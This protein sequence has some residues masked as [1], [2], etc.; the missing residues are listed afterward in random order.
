MGYDAR[1]GQV[2]KAYDVATDAVGK[3]SQILPLEARTYLRGVLPSFK[4]EVLGSK[5]YLL[6]KNHPL[7]ENILEE[8]K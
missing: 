1:Q 6:R 7:V 4:D 5:K 2:S 8:M 3:V